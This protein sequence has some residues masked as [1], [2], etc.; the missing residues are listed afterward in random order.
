MGGGIITPCA[1][2]HHSRWRGVVVFMTQPFYTLGKM[3]LVTAE[4]W[5]I[6]RADLEY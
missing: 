6:P 4:C 5:L 2:N 3:T 1:T